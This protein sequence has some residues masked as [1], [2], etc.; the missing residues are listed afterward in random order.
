MKKNILVVGT[1]FAG[2]TVARELAD[3][4]RFKIHIIDKR[5]HIA[6]NA[7]DPV[8]DQLKLRIHRYGPHIFHTNDQRIFDYLSRFTQ[9]LPYIH[10]VQA[11]VEGTGYVPLPINRSTLNKIYNKSLTDEA[12]VKAFLETLRCHH[13]H[14]AN[15]REMAENIYG[16]ELTELFFARYTLKMWGM[17]LSDLASEVLARLPVRYDDNVNYFDDKIQVMPAHGYLGLFETMLDHPDISITLACQFDKAMEKDYEHVFNSMPIDA[18]FNEQFGALPYRSI[19]FVHEQIEQHHQPVPT[20]NFTNQGIYTRQTDWRLYPGCDL[21]ANQAFLTKEIPCSYE[22]NN[23]ERYY[24][25]K[26]VDGAPQRL[27]RR[28]CEEARKL[29]HMTFIGR[30]GQ[31]IYYDMHQVVA[32]SLKMAKEYL[33]VNR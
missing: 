29:A 33:A 26:T 13:K 2:A 3:S 1:G 14:P 21:G 31:Y 28:Y 19:Q 6:G 16:V 20:I 24:P 27:Y 5:D 23:F 8:D 9:W 7:F 15:A 18:Y 17:S 25:V 32:N 22:E 30:C 11:L 4:G 10:Q 12:D